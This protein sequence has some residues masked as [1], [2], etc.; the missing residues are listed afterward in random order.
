KTARQDPFSKD[1][2]ALICNVTDPKTGKTYSRDSRYVAQKATEHLKRS[3]VADVS[4]WGP[5]M[6]FYIFDDIRFEQREGEAFYKIDSE[7]APWNTGTRMEGR[8]LGHRARYKGGYF[9]V[10]TDAL[11]NLRAEMS[12]NLQR[13]GIP[14]EMQHHE[15]GAAGQAEIDMHFDDLVTMADNS[16]WYVHIT[17]ENAK[18]EKKLVTF[19]PKPIFGDNG[20]GMHVHQSLWKGKGEDAKN[21]FYDKTG[22][23]LLSEEALHYIGGLLAHAPA[24]CAII[25]PTTNSYRRLIPGFEAP[26]NLVLSA[27]NRSAAVR[28][29]EYSE[30]PGARRVEFRTP[31]PTANRYL[32]FSAMLMAGLDGIERK[33]DPGKPID[34]D[35][36]KLPQE[37]LAKIRSV[38]RSLDEALDALERDNEF[39][40][41]G[42]VFTPDLLNKY[43]EIKRAETQEVR[44]RPHP[45]EFAL[46]SHY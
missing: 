10:S 2:L 20:S 16:M 43:V 1:T 34:K 44:E 26:V 19:M 24:L 12:R 38:P 7:E 21:V 9:P 35:I 39:L 18:K 25:A 23:A 14:V 31:D 36:Y 30:N 3:G 28:I 33:I 22:Y 41:K 11:K 4:Y 46:Y 45:H 6:E 8:N 5:E 15:V 32:A 40:Y 27:G 37:E 42:N 17:K 29:P 13:V